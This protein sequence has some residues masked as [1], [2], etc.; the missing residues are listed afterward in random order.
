MVSNIS[1]F[2]DRLSKRWFTISAITHEKEAGVIAMIRWLSFS[3][4]PIC[5][6]PEWRW[7]VTRRLE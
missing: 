7:M 5:K 3:C 6:Q 1:V 2:G 4:L